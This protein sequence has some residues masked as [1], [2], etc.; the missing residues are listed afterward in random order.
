MQVK[1]I[2]IPPRHEIRPY[3]Q[4]II[5][6]QSQEIIGYESLG[7][8][9]RD[10]G[11]ESLGPFFQDPD[12]SED[13]QLMIDRHL[14]EQAIERVA[15]SP[16]PSKLFINLKPSWIYRTYKRTGV[17]PTI[18]LAK[19]YQ[20]DPSQIVIEITEEEFKGQLQ[21]LTWII[22]LYRE[23]GC[24]IAIDDVGSGFSNLDRIASLQPKILKI[25]LNIL[26]KSIVHDGY[27]AL[28]QSFSIL[29][30]Q[31]GASL[32][33]EGVETKRELHT[34]LHAGA[35]YVQGFLFSQAEVDLQQ[36]D[37]Y[38]GMLA[39]ELQ[40]FGQGQFERY[41][42]LL[43][44]HEGLSTLIHSSAG[45]SNADEADAVLEQMIHNVSDNCIRMYICQG[46]GYQTSSNYT[47]NEE[48]WSKNESYRQANWAWRPY[49]ISNILMMN[50]QKQG[51]LSQVYTDLDTSY[52]IQTFSCALGEGYYLF[53]DLM[54]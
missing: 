18:E 41:S 21:E 54:I 28:L 46:D 45:I 8:W 2:K 36:P 44:V 32:L 27:R 12:I 20:I 42:Q 52:Q 1:N 10:G 13:M 49:F 31:M 6:L 51:T 53:L 15:E 24:T 25:D 11:V 23:F 35:R 14:R 19:K 47:R 39:E 4:P 9:I 37:A 30:S 48:G 43:T 50:V 38:K 26:K 29:S 33:V 3:Y 40:R 22:E 17:L 34:A 5:S 7:R 16:Y